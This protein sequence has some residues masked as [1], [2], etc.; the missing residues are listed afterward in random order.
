MGHNC[1]LRPFFIVMG[2]RCVDWD[3]WLTREQIPC[4]T[5]GDVL[6]IRC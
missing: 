2:W 5:V 4:G 3:G 1:R 6:S